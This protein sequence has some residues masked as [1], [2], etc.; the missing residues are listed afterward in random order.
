MQAYELIID[1]K[2]KASPFTIVSVDD[3]QTH[4][5]QPLDPHSILE[6]PDVS[7]YCI[8]HGNRQAIFVQTAPEVDLLQA[9]FYFRA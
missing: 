1:A 6:R 7:L 9:P 5:G 8:D 3:F 2:A 4:P